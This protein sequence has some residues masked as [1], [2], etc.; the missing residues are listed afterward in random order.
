MGQ[1]DFDRRVVGGLPEQPELRAQCQPEIG[2][3]GISPKH[4]AAIWQ[5]ISRVLA[6]GGCGII[7]SPCGCITVSAQTASMM[8]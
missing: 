2:K 6:E 1:T 5:Q 3:I 8:G 7:S 4:N